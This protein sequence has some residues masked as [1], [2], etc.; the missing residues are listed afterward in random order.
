MKWC[1]EF[2]V[3]ECTRC[4]HLNR[5]NSRVTCAREKAFSFSTRFPCEPCNSVTMDVH[6]CL[7]EVQKFRAKVN[8]LSAFAINQNQ[9]CSPD[10][11]NLFILIYI[12]CASSFVKLDSPKTTA[13]DETIQRV[14][15]FTWQSRM[16]RTI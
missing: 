8:T 13:T 1:E 11:M 10:A 2:V 6:V 12:V 3:G 16:S 9:R 14:C 15:V 4:S 5:L 7:C